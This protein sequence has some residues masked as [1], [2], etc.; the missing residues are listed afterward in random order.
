LARVRLRWLDGW[1]DGWE[2][3][4]IG[5]RRDTSAIEAAGKEKEH[6]AKEEVVQ[7]FAPVAIL[8]SPNAT[9]PVSMGGGGCWWW[10]IYI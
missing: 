4:R 6:P 8:L 7:G 2:E 10:W 1:M 3:R 5:W 9:W